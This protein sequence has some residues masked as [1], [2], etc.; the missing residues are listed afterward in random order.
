VGRAFPD[1][2]PTDAYSDRQT[3]RAD[4]EAKIWLAG[5]IR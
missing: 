2:F 5:E 1:L 3:V 4:V